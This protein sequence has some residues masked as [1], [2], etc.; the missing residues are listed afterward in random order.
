MRFRQLPLA[1][2]ALVLPSLFL[3]GC[4]SS[5]PQQVA[6]VHTSIYEGAIEFEGDPIVCKRLQLLNTRIKKNVC[7]RR[8]EWERREHEAQDWLRRQTPSVPRE[9]RMPVPQAQ[10]EGSKR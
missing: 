1:A 10:P 2:G 9:L 5:K 4:A 3:F 8:S 7:D 6:A